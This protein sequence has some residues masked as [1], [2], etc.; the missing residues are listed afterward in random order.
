MKFYH[1][2]LVCLLVIVLS[3]NTV[4]AVTNEE[5][6]KVTYPFARTVFPP[7]IAPPQFIWKDSSSSGKWEVSLLL[8]NGKTLAKEVV[9]KCNWQP[10]NEQWKLFTK[11]TVDKWAKIRVRHLDS[12]GKQGNG[13]SEVEICTSRDAVEAPIFYRDV[14]LPFI[15]AVKDPTK[16]KWRFGPVSSRSAPPVVLE[17]LPVCG[18]CHSFSA[19]GSLLGM[20][21]DYANDKGSYVITKIKKE[22][23]LSKSQVITWAD[24]KKD[25]GVK[26]F[27]LLSQLSPDGRYAVSTVNDLSVFVP[28]PSLAFSQL[29]FPVK[30]ILAVYDR[31]KDKYTPLPGADSPDHVQSNPCWSPDGK[32][33]LFARALKH[34]LPNVVIENNTV[35]LLTA[36][37]CAEF[38]RD[39]KKFRFD[40]YRIPFNEGKG[41]KAEPLPGASLNGRSNFFPKYSPDGKWIVYC[42]A[43]SYMLLQKDSELY[44]MPASGGKARRMKCNT[45]RM[46]SW[47]SWSPNSKWLVFASKAFSA[48]TQLFL[49][50]IDDEGHSTPPVLLH[51]FVSKNR[52]A[53]IPEFVNTSS[54]AIEK[55]NEQFVDDVSFVRAANEYVRAKEYDKAR[56]LC[57]RALSINPDN[58]LALRTVGN[59]LYSHGQLEAAIEHYKRA[60]AVHSDNSDVQYMLG[61]ALY[62]LGKKAEGKKHLLLAALG[63]P[64]DPLIQVSIGNVFFQQKSYDLA[65]ARYRAALHYD[66]GC[67]FARL[68]LARALKMKGQ[69]DKALNQLKTLALTGIRNWEVYNDLGQLQVVVGDVK[70][71]IQSLSEAQKLA[72]KGK[73]EPTVHLALLEISRRNME[74]AEKYLHAA[75]SISPRNGRAHAAMGHLMMKTNRF[76]AAEKHYRAALFGAQDKSSIHCD[77]AK[78]YEKKGKKRLARL[79]YQKAIEDDPANALAKRA[80]QRI[81]R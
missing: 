80:L 12:G 73:V 33:L 16:I 2:S 5:G 64:N 11:N 44:I 21:V 42:Q 4:H 39:N 22:M 37:M 58:E 28:A 7:D 54:K 13:L 6:V 19:D 67:W 32:Y 27:G 23:T 20:D 55:I 57:Q 70:D 38:L 53:N 47:H 9:Q 52:A 69:I 30:G 60:I 59:V 36:D 66:E 3:P 50:H 81:N 62:Q 72:P 24:F 51:N 48:Y 18:N 26:T 65:V 43:D 34:E 79:H 71:A 25:E 56:E 8:P 77:L 63:K 40:I 17:K 14:N 46:N 1:M 75:L 78:L 10:S 61:K 45:S 35:P 68:R 74:E 29:F 31:Q 49:T 15:S 41:G 76:H